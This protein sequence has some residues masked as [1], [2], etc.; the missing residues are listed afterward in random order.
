MTF[1]AKKKMHRLLILLALLASLF[2]LP[3]HAADPIEPEKAFAMTAR[4]L[5]PQT[6]EVVFTVAKDYYLYGDKFRLYAEPASVV[7]GEPDRPPG[8]IKKDEFFGEVET[9]RKTLRM[10]VP[11]TAP[12]EITRFE[13]TVSSQGCW[14]GGI[15]Y[16]PTEQIAMIDLSASPA[17]GSGGLLD[18]ALLGG[19]GAT[20]AT[21]EADLSGDES[22]RIAGLLKDA[23]VPLVLA[24][25]FGFGLLLA[26][27][28]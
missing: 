28:P 7:L 25:F 15:C 16:P 18:R 8:K 6:V 3:T 22:G 26:F 2:S 21:A 24:S 10:L 4:A 17:P 14:D 1:T 9:Y 5:D 19:G 27:T 13:L 20:D 11:V 23:S 12:P